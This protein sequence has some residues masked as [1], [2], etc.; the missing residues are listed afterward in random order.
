VLY[1]DS[2]IDASLLSLYIQQNYTQY[3][4]DIDEC[5]AEADWLSWIDSSG[6]EAWY[7]ANPHHFHLLAL[8]TLHSLPSP[9]ARRNQVSYKPAFFDALQR[10]RGAEDG[11]RDTQLWLQRNEESPI[12]SWSTRDVAIE[13]GGVLKARDLAGTSSSTLPTTHRRFSRFDFEEVTKGL[14]QL[15]ADG[16][17]PQHVTPDEYGANS[18]R[19][20]GDIQGPDSGGWLEDDTIEEF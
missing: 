8:S 7:Q 15:T 14:V 20:D 6:G 5:G 16:D 1:A 11:L 10:Q 19:D 4:N 2:P 13:L 3:C 18:V 12:G 17:V 9:V